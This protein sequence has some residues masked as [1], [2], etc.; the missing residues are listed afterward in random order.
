MNHTHVQASNIKFIAC[1]H[2]S[3]YS[4]FVIAGTGTDIK[5]CAALNRRMFLRFGKTHFTD[6]N[7]VHFLTV[8][9]I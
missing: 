5:L 8:F 6:M 3:Q 7:A 2:I 9:D 4:K 1:P